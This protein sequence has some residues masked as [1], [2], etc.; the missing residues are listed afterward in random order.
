MNTVQQLPSSRLPL[1]PA[2]S[3]EKASVS[4]SREEGARP[5]RFAEFPKTL[6][7]ELEE[8]DARACRAEP[9]H[10]FSDNR[11]AQYVCR[12]CM[13][14]LALQDEVVSK[15]FSGSLGQAYLM[16]STVNTYLGKKEDKRLLTGMHTVADLLCMGC[17]QSGR[18]TTLGWMYL[19]AKERDQQYKEG[20]YILEAARVIKENNWSLDD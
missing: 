2:V 9:I 3:P 6:H 5:S 12:E 11:H 10:Y 20:K 4:P 1:S 17:Q 15:A 19:K 8:Y 16:H 7:A 18:K 14:P 13:T